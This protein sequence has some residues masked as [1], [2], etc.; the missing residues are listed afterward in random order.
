MNCEASSI[1]WDGP[2][3]TSDAETCSVVSAVEST[4]CI[5]ARIPLTLGRTVI[6]PSCPR[7]EPPGDAVLFGNQLRLHDES[8]RRMSDEL[9]RVA[10]D[11]GERRLL[12]GIEHIDVFRLDDDGL[13]DP[14]SIDAVG[15]REIERIPDMDVPQSPEDR[16]AMS[17][18]PDVP[19]LPG[20]R[21]IF[22][23]PRGPSQRAVVAAFE[24]G[25]GDLD[26]RNFEPRD[27]RS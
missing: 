6:W 1:G 12:S 22:D 13:T 11:E 8:M 9:E 27:P 25:R 21:C 17:G 19:R 23:V 14:I 10:G 20:Q 24:H 15:R 26:C 4:G 18:D 5:A 2:I 7:L 3:T 16:V